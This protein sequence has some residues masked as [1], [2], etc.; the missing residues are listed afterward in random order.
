MRRQIIPMSGVCPKAEQIVWKAIAEKQSLGPNWVLL[1]VTGRL[2]KKDEDVWIYTICLF[3][4]LR[5]PE[6]QYWERQ[7]D[8]SK[9]L[10]HLAPDTGKKS[11]TTLYKVSDEDRAAIFD[12]EANTTTGQ[13]IFT[14]ETILASLNPSDFELTYEETFSDELERLIGETRSLLE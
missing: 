1:N 13:V 12:A 9:L 4:K 6:G 10:D 14:K 5:L 3:K 7:S 11:Y 2:Q 8:G